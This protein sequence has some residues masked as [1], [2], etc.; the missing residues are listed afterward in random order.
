MVAMHDLTRINEYEWEI[1]TSY[2]QDMRVPVRLF[3]TRRML[4]ESMRD[5]S[6][7]QAVNAATLPGLVGHV[8]VM[9]DMHQ[10]YGFPIGGV[11]ATRLPDGVISP[12]AIGYDINCGVRLL[13]SHISADEA[14]SR[15]D[16]LASALDEFC[17]SG[18]GSKSSVHLSEAELNQVCLK[19]STWAFEHGF[20][21]E[22]DLR[23]TEESGRLEGADPSRVSKRA[24]ER[25][26]PQLGTL[27]IGQSLH[28]SGCDRSN[29]RCPG[30]RG[31]RPGGGKPG[32]ANPLRV[33]RLLGTRYAVIMWKISGSRKSLQDTATR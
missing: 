24:K 16:A 15:L 27:G 11:A 4:E 6:L 9:P 21:T 17:P 29:I 7:D 8:I 19:G 33:P 31:L 1:P 25:G 10:G 13:G 18:V 30:S 2:R 23:R 20:A 14:G 22:A 26:R 12:G 3:S 32:S 5:Q 28:R